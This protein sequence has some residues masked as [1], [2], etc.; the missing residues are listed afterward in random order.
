VLQAWE[1]EEGRDPIKWSEFTEYLEE[2]ECTKRRRR[3]DG[4]NLVTVWVGIRLLGDDE[5]DRKA[6]D[7]LASEVGHA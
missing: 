4:P 1:R 7:D 6:A 2:R 5:L 3:L